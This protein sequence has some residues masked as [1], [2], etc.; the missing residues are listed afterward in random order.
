MLTPI[1]STYLVVAGMDQTIV[2][3]PSDEL[4]RHREST[5]PK[6]VAD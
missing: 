1:D 4:S 3:E 5:P 6:V 2:S